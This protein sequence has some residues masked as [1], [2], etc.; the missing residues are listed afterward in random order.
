LNDSG[1]FVEHEFFLERYQHRADKMTVHAAHYRNN[2]SGDLVV[3]ISV[4][5]GSFVE[6]KRQTF[7]DSTGGFSTFGSAFLDNF[8]FTDADFD[9][10]NFPTSM[11]I[12][13]RV[14]VENVTGVGQVFLDFIQVNDELDRRGIPRYREL[15]PYDAERFGFNAGFLL[16]QYNPVTLKLKQIDSP[17]AFNEL[18][19]ESE[20][21]GSDFFVD[22]EGPEGNFDGPVT[23]FKIEASNDGGETYIESQNDT[24][25]TFNFPQ[26]GNTIDVKVTLDG[27]WD[28][29]DTGFE[30]VPPAPNKGMDLDK[31]TFA[32]GTDPLTKEGIGGVNLRA[33][34]RPRTITAGGDFVTEGGLFDTNGDMVC[35][36]I[37]IAPFDPGSNTRVST[38]DTITITAAE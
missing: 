20:V 29:G 25:P 35:R 21:I 38:D 30:D 15:S 37:A 16:S 22:V 33:I 4:N 2:F 23:E 14:E 31:M 24:D 9:P 10:D 3:S 28:R 27:Y 18:S 5:G 12:K 1:E 17:I 6:V 13:V 19:I 26:E 32:V 11:T 7:E 36:T 34:F 8:G